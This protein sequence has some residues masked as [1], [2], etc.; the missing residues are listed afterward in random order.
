[1]VA[2]GSAA[3]AGHEDEI[4]VYAEG[5]WSFAAPQPGWCAQVLNPVGALV[6]DAPADWQV[7][8]VTVQQAPQL[9]I[10][11]TADA[12]N[13]LSLSAPRFADGTQICTHE[14]TAGFNNN[15]RLSARWIFPAGFSVMP[16]CSGMLWVGN[17]PSEITPPRSDITGVMRGDSNTT[18]CDFVIYRI[19]GGTDFV[20]GDTTPIQ[21]T[22]IGR[23]F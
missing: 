19:T 14:L 17:M 3:W 16:N 20:A 15:E 9:G 18:L 6:Y 8:V 2:P 11:A 13:R 21:V 10:N 4:A 12:T 5:G 7:P 1:M 23:W 22:A